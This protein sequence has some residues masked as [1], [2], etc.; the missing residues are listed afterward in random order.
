MPLKVTFRRDVILSSG[1]A[2]DEEW[3]EMLLQGGKEGVLGFLEEDLEAF[4]DDVEGL[5]GII[6]SVEVVP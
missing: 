4:L 3:R 1:W 6:Q 5:Q 2:T